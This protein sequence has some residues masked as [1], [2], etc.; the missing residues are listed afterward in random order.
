MYKLKQWLLTAVFATLA[1]CSGG[2]DE[3]LTGGG[4]TGSG[5][6]E[7]GSLRVLTSSPQIPSDG[8]ASATITALVLDTN[9]NV[10]ENVPV[11]LSASSGSL[12]VVQ[13]AVTD[14]SGTVTATLTTAGDPTNRPITITG[15]ARSSAGSV[16]VNVI[17]SALTITGP[18]SLAL[19]GT[20][21]FNVVLTNA[22]GKGI[23]NRSVA[24]SSALGNAISQTPV[25]TDDQGRATFAVTANVGGSDT[26]TASALG[27]NATAAVSVSNVTFTFSTPAANTE[28]PLGANATIT[29]NYS[30]SGAG[31]AGQTISFSTTRGTLS[32]AQAATN[33]SGDATVTVSANNAG[34]ALITATNILNGTTIQ[35]TVEF[36]ATVPAT[37]ELQASPFTVAT[38]DQAT[39]TAI[40]RDAAGNL[41]KN[42][43]VNFVLTDTSNGSLTVAQAVTNSQGRAQT[44][45]TASNSTSAVDGVRIDATVIGT[46]VTDFVRLTVA[47]RELFMSLGTG[48]E[49]AEPNTAQYRQ[50][51]VLQVTDAQGNGVDLVPVT[52]S[53]HSVRYWEGRRA[54]V[55]PPG[56]WVTARGSEALPAIGC[57]DED[58]NRNGILDV[59]PDEDFNDSGLIEAGNIASVIARGGGSTV[60]TDQNGFALIDIYYPQ[61]YAEWLEVTLEVRTSVQGTEFRRSAT[62]VLA[63][64]A[65]DFQNEDIAP[66]GVDSPF[67]TDGLCNTP[68][69]PLGP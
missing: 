68:P 39:I 26:I 8:T 46:A 50:E 21:T 55:D 45:Y 64:L 38:N 32:A 34:A 13:P 35:R 37:L 18:S 44:F 48:N 31:V 5:S 33:A 60:I 7:V 6:G 25:V 24:I 42:Q 61:Q 51:W 43:V 41:V 23:A 67:G 29:V 11:V 65:S 47:Q 3:T 36:V 56:L 9:N 49:I 57:Q 63:G 30:Q 27:I 28:I 20:E 53:V 22:G 52:L 19:N 17:G 10:M 54:F 1:A 16:V 66:P 62:F 4:T 69:P 2:G 14:E 58:Q 15:R 59:V 12:A 40:V